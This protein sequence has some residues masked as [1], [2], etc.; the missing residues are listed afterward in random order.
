[1]KWN[2]INNKDY[3]KIYEHKYGSFDHYGPKFFNGSAP[4]NKLSHAIAQHKTH[5]PINSSLQNMSP[6]GPS[7]TE[8]KVQNSV[9][10]E[11]VLA[12][13][14]RTN[15]F[16][17]APK[18]ACAVCKTSRSTLQTI[19]ISQLCVCVSFH[20]L[21]TRA[22]H[23]HSAHTSCSR[24]CLNFSLFCLSHA[25]TCPTRKMRER[26][27]CP[28][29]RQRSRRH[30]DISL[31]RDG[32]F[33]HQKIHHHIV[34]ASRTIDANNNTVNMVERTHALQI[35]RTDPKSVEYTGGSTCRLIHSCIRRVGPRTSTHK[36]FSIGARTSKGCV[37]FPNAARFCLSS[38][39]PASNT[40]VQHV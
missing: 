14:F 28:L 31:V 5:D 26:N 39:A 21:C 13:V 34:R 32:I 10:F 1:M 8:K 4:A 16:I 35:F 37:G 12:R 7:S 33:W 27:G 24:L 19:C 29:T 23:N 30:N 18:G 3:L 9:W 22:E 17:N 2:E 38:S 11:L 6:L 15:R 36:Q 25:K 20:R 40:H